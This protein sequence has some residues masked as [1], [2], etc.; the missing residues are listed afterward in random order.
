MLKKSVVIGAHKF[1]KNRPVP[2]EYKSIVFLCLFICGVV[3]GVMLS[4]KGNESWHSAFGTLIK[5]HLTAKQGSSLLVNFCGAFTPLLVLLVYDYVFGMCGVGTM[6]LHLTP[7][8]LGVLSGVCGAEF[9]HQ[10]ALEGLVYWCCVNIPCNAIA[11]ASLIKCC[12]YGSELSNYVFSVLIYPKT[13]R[14]EGVLKEYTL[15]FLVMTLPIALGSMLNAITFMLVGKLF[16]FL[17]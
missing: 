1:R 14:K 2:T 6:F 8:V 9:Y 3:F 13:E 10:L 15:N 7:I 12:C 17:S 5:N 16:S 4:S 11:A